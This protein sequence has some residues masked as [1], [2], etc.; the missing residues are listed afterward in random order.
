[1]NYLMPALQAS[2]RFGWT[3]CVRLLVT[4]GCASKQLSSAATPC[5]C[6][7]AARSVSFVVQCL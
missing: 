5:G 4:A 1:V 7:S 2:I 3:K 6:L